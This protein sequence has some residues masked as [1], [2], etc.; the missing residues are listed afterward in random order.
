M[1]RE[2]KKLDTKIQ[3]ILDDGPLAGRPRFSGLTGLVKKVKIYSS[4]SPWR[5]AFV[6]DGEDV[7]VLAAMRRD[8]PDCD[9]KLLRLAEKRLKE[10]SDED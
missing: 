4:N 10:L 1:G 9:Q 8:T 5:V 6:W 3:A 2:Q 7:V